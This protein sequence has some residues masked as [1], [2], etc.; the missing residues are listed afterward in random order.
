MPI[1][2]HHSASVQEIN[3]TDLRPDHEFA[4]PGS[5][6]VTLESIRAARRRNNRDTLLGFT[7]IAALMIG[8]YVAAVAAPTSPLADA[9]AKGLA[10]LI[11]L[12]GAASL[13]W[14]LGV[15]IVARRRGRR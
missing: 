1:E 2:T 3:G 8:Y 10:A 6:T 9:I 13:G 4:Q 5:Y 14:A 7:L 12:T 15:R 11:Y